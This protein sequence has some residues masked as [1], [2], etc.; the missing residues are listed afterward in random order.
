MKPGR[1]C[2]LRFFGSVILAR[3]R[4]LWLAPRLVAT[5][6]PV[7]LAACGGSG[8]SPPCVQ[9]FYVAPTGSDAASGD[10]SHPF[11]TLNK[12]RDAVRV[13]PRRGE[14]MLR[15]NLV[16]G[17]YRL[18]STLTLDGRDSGTDRGDVIYRA[19]PGAQAVLSGALSVKTWTLHNAG[20]NIWKASTSVA[21]GVMPRQ[22]YV[23]GVRATR[24][25]TPGY[26]NYYQP[27]PTGYEYKYTSGNDPQ[28]PPVWTY[29]G[30]AE[31]VSSTQWKMM[32]CPVKSVQGNSVTAQ[33]RCWNN[34]NLFPYPWN[35][36]LLSWIENAEEFLDE[37]GEW[38]LR[39]DTR[40][41]LYIPRPGED[42]SIAEVEIPV[43]EKLVDGSGDETT[44]LAHLRFENLTFRHTTWFDPNGVDGYA[45]DQSGF[46]VVGE[47]H[48]PN[49]IGHDPDTIRTPGGLHFIY[50]RNLTLTGNRFQ[51]MGAVGLDLDTGSQEI[52]VTDNVFSDLSAAAIQL[53]GVG[54]N[55][56]HPSS[57]AQ[58]T[59]DN[60]IA[61]NL[62][63]YIG[64]EYYDA[65]G[66]FLGFTTRT[67]VRNNDIAHVPWTGIAIGWGWGM[68]DPGEGFAGVP[69]AKLYEWGVFK[70]PSAAQG[71]RII[72]NRIQ[73]Y[74]EKLW[75][76]GAV[77][78]QGFQGTSMDDGQLIAW[79]VARHK[80]AASGSNTFYTDGGSRFVTVRENVSLDNPVGTV[81]FGPC[82]VSSSLLPEGLCTLT[83]LIP[84]GADMGGCIPYGDLQ[85]IGNYFGDHLTFYDMPLCVNALFPQNPVRMSF[86]SN[87]KIQS[88]S[89]V[90]AWIMQAA[91]R[92]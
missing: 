50:A 27:T 46:H 39:P 26:P 90:P 13:E 14:C 47:G 85:F 80:R 21:P 20:K 86:N 30:V 91:G 53:G 4:P 3:F 43:L 73:Y 77:Y 2:Q 63:E 65:P 25:R 32:R 41:L 37:P 38:F 44:A 6:F 84:Y 40:E 64:Q 23:N 62:I 55:D 8:S 74:L 70:T 9:D 18:A 45:L 42:L 36:H 83:G 33:P 34:A 89:D 16:S 54:A 87:V 15:V 67:L 69:G 48:L 1:S 57:A 22:I 35:F 58:L 28:I 19:A 71:N 59:R 75:D 10:E 56:H 49:V 5:I 66:I 72:H 29:P 51:Q 81:D 68:L 31:L 12:A 52:S 92:Q 79:N 24:A 78:T 11:A 7:I 82:T 88:V 61:N 17:V 76:G 60:T